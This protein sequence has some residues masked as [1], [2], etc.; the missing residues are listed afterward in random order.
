MKNKFDAKSELNRFYNTSS[1]KKIFLIGTPEH[2]N[3]G[4]QAIAY[5][6][7]KMLKDNFINMDIFEIQFS[8][9]EDYVDYLSS[10]ITKEDIIMLHGGGNMGDE[11]I[12]EEEARRNI[13]KK[14]KKQKIIIF[15][16]TIFFSENEQGEKELQRTKQIYNSH[17]DLV[18]IAREK[19]SYKK[20]LEVFTRNK[21]LLTPDIVMYLNQS[22][23]SEKREGIVICFRNDQEKTISTDYKNKVIE[24]LVKN[25]KVSVT[26]TIVGYSIEKNSRESELQRIWTDFRKA[27]LVITDRLHGMVF[28]AITGTPCIAFSNYNQKVLGTFQWIKHIPNIV[29][30]EKQEDLEPHIKKLKEIN[31]SSYNN[32][33]TKKYYKSILTEITNSKL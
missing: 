13:I 24:S 16:Q 4:D 11:Y 9:I 10:K 31:F 8:K 3:L 1:K 19:V 27:E 7:I 17:A 30:M 15:P 29:Y 2:G 28:A 32:D 33:F 23:P 25:Y 6:Q 14:F 21:V 20:M 12:R 18:I 5:A 22:Y 26:D